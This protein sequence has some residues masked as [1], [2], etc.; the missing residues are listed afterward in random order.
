MPPHASELSETRRT[1]V[2]S[3][4]AR[5]PLS[6]WHRRPR[7]ATDSTTTADTTVIRAALR[8]IVT[9]GDS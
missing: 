2:V 9:I 5:L 3:N 8:T 1:L 4:A 6:R 7:M